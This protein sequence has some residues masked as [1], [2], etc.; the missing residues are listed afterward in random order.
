MRAATAPATDAR[1]VAIVTKEEAALP[2]VEQFLAAAFQT[3]FLNSADQIL[4]LLSQVPLDA[5]ILD[6]DT[7]AETTNGGLDVLTELRRINEDYVLVALTRSKNR[8]VRVK[9]GELGADE[10]FVRAV[11]FR[12]L[13]VVV[14]RA[15]DKRSIEIERRQVGEQLVSKYFFCGLIG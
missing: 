3:T 7:V 10:F 12:G 15:L 6:I 5:I 13:E 8:S 14:E 1:R 11:G 9:A 4:P 2:D